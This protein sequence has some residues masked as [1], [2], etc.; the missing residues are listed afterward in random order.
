MGVFADHQPIYASHNIPTFPMKG[1]KPAVKYFTRL[2]LK[3][4]EQLAFKFPNIDALGFMAGRQS[5]ITVLDIDS[6]DE[7]LLRDMMKRLGQTAI[8]LQSGSGNFHAWYRFN[9]ESR[10]VRPDPSIPVDLLGGGVAVAP[11]SKS[12]TGSYQFI[13]GSLDDLHKLRP[14]ANVIE[15]PKPKLVQPVA[16]T[17]GLIGAGGRSNALFR[18][19]MREARHCDDLEDLLDVAFTYANAFIDRTTGHTF[20]DAEITTTARSVYEIT[21]RGDNRFG[22]EPHTILSNSI[23][24]QVQELGADAYFLHSVLMKWAGSDKEFPCANGMADHMPGGKWNTKRFSKARRALLESG[25]IKEV[26]K[27][28]T[29]H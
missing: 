8:I 4:S 26:R 9:G 10:K 19:L 21:E 20:T 5:G 2:G 24:D 11:P 14:A 18:H 15:F 7:D 28:Y 27:A 3:A 6:P 17:R 16:A 13:Y 1:K 25:I 12:K 23:R 29:G 22:G